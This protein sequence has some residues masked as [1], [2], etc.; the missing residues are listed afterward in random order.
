MTWYINCTID[1]WCVFSAI[2]AHPASLEVMKH[3]GVASHRLGGVKSLGPQI[4]HGTFWRFYSLEIWGIIRKNRGF[5]KGTA[6]EKEIP[7]IFRGWKIC[8]VQKFP[9]IP[10]IC[11]ALRVENFLNDQCEFRKNFSVHSA[12]FQSHE[13]FWMAI[14]WCHLWTAIQ[15]FSKVFAKT[16]PWFSWNLVKY[17]CSF[18]VKLW[19]PIG[20]LCEFYR[21]KKH[22]ILLLSPRL[23]VCTILIQHDKFLNSDFDIVHRKDKDDFGWMF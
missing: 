2:K 14:F 8:R 3:V 4:S 20:S 10:M 17:L 9:K 11:Q 15:L 6:F 16:C 22:P 21:Q 12:T 5:W 7:T 19:N 1:A 18:N 13:A 23:H